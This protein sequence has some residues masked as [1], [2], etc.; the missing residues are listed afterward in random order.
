MGIEIPD[1]MTDFYRSL[2]LDRIEVMAKELSE[3]ESDLAYHVAAGHPRDQRFEERR[4]A[5]KCDAVALS[6]L[7]HH[8]ETLWGLSEAECLRDVAELLPVAY[9]MARAEWESRN[10]TG[11]RNWKPGPNV[12]PVERKRSGNAG[13]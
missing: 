7:V 3:D 4:S 10:T 6:K 13:E 11:N 8:A 1:H 12:V 9:V 5:L 2:I